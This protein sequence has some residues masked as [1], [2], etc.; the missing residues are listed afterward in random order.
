MN[1]LKKGAQKPINQTK[2]ARNTTKTLAK[3]SN[4]LN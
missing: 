1:I 3:C 2:K 4:T